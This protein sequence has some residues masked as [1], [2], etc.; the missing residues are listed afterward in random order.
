[1]SGFRCYTRK[2]S[3]KTLIQALRWPN[4]T[5]QVIDSIWLVAKFRYLAKQRNFFADQGNKY[6]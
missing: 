3:K 2:N 1:V 6:G 4:L 5:S